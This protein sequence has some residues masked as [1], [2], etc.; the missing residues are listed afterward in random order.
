[1]SAQNSLRRRQPWQ[2][3]VSLPRH[4]T[5]ENRPNGLYHHRLNLHGTAPVLAPIFARN[6]ML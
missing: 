1:M 5:H 2:V 4:R 6:L 3:D